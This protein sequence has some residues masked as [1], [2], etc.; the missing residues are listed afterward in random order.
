MD[1]HDNEEV[2]LPMFKGRY[3]NGTGAFNVSL[4]NGV[5]RLTA[6]DLVGKG[7]PVPKVYMDEIRTHQAG[8]RR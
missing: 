4:R 5:I 6:L 1:Q 2:G 3:L 7:K 8:Y